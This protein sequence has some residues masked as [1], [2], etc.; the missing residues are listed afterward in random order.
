MLRELPTLIGDIALSVENF[1]LSEGDV[2]EERQ[3]P[4]YEIPVPR[5]VLAAEGRGALNT[6]RLSEEVQLLNDM[7][8]GVA[9]HFA[10]ESGRK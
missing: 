10:L 2:L 5:R 6:V 3:C 7:A 9:H 1:V 4:P 8:V